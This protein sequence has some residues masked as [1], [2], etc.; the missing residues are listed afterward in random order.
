M[1]I[2]Q[3]VS[4]LILL[5][6]LGATVASAQDPQGDGHDHEHGADLT[7]LPLGDQ[8]ESTAPQRGYIWLC[9]R[10]EGNLPPAPAIGYWID[11]EAGTWDATAK[12][13]IAG[14]V[15]WDNYTYSFQ[16]VDG[17]RL[18]TSN[19]L[20]SHPT[21]VFPVQPSDPAYQYDRN[22]NSINEQ[23]FSFA[24]PANPA[25]AATPSC[26]GG[27]VGIT[28]EGIIIFNGF[29][30]L[31]YDAVAHEVQDECDGHPQVTGQYHYH[32]L[33]SC[34]EDYEAGEGHS[35]LIGY[36]FDGFGIYGYRG[37]DGQLMTNTDLDDCHGHTH[38]IEWDGQQVE[39]YHYHATAEFPYTVGCYRGTSV[40]GP[41]GRGLNGQTQTGPQQGQGGQGQNQQGGN[42][43]PPPNGQ[44][45]NPPP[46]PPGR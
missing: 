14:E 10:A 46:P 18:V 17:Q 11:V 3:I 15:V 24:L 30:A 19:N 21:G 7:Q 22:P 38:T 2:K 20:P 43:P 39:M 36:A 40:I 25:L 35:A 12:P 27:E 16:L 1:R 26:V 23:A 8:K 44:G 45:G 4:L 42:P 29:D 31:G 9:G 41:G 37:E 32:S 13:S 33:S 5:A 6:L 28:L 34:I